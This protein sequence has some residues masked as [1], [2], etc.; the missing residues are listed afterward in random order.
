MAW[1]SARGVARR[2][3]CAYWEFG[4]GPAVLRERVRELSFP[5]IACNVT[6]GDTGH[7]EFAAVNIREVGG[8]RIAFVGITSP[9]VSQTMPQA[10]GA[11][12]RFLDALDVLPPSPIASTASTS[13]S[14]GTPTTCSRM[15][16]SWDERSLRS[17]ARMVPT[18]LV[19]ISRSPTDASVISGVGCCR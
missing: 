11:G 16:L 15:R 12:L 3:V 10:F 18:L 14:A 8:A 5:V 6:Q 1:R 13:S 17:P 19:S 7:R 4:F 2:R 9:I